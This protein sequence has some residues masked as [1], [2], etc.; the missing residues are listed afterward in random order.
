MARAV[1]LLFAAAL[2]A[3]VGCTPAAPSFAGD[4]SPELGAYFAAERG[5]GTCHSDGHGTLAGSSRPIPKTTVYAS[6]LTPDPETGLGNWADSQI[7]RALRTGV[8]D[9]LQ[10]LC[11]SM[12]HYDDLGDLEGRSL[13][14]YLRSLPAVARPDIPESRCPPIKPFDAALWPGMD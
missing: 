3:A 10:F 1:P 11:P 2:A 12:I 4:P 7:L 5:C 13:V 8:D 14:A 9:N 6:N